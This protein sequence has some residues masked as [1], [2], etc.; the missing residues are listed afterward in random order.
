MGEHR[1]DQLAARRQPQPRPLV[2]EASEPSD[3]LAEGPRPP[4]R[5][6][7]RSGARSAWRRN[8]QRL[9]A[10][11]HTRTGRWTL[12]AVAGVVVLLIGLI[13][14]GAFSSS[15][16]V[17]STPDGADA[18]PHA[19]AANNLPTAP[20]S[21]ARASS[22]KSGAAGTGLVKDP[23]KALR[24]AF[25]DNPLNHLDKQGLH[26]VT[27]SA[28]SAG[29]MPVIGYLVPTG[30]GSAYGS[31]HTHRGHWSL[32][33]QALGKGYLAALFIQA[34]KLGLPVTCTVTVDGKVTNSETTSGSYGRAVC[35]G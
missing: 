7:R 1:V 9:S 30:L 8:R 18:T 5:P 34:D 25:P 24:G 23:V 33:E 11:L 6:R 20:P 4:A 16:S 32:H 22:S 28:T 17:G 29:N 31:V 15:G 13:A 19:V 2:H 27:I 3:P 35:L 21:K 14:Q 26:E 10:G 12:I